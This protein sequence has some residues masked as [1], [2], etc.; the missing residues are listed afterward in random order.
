MITMP[1]L[2]NTARPSK[3]RPL[4]HAIASPRAKDTIV[5]LAYSQNQMQLPFIRSERKLSMS[6]SLIWV[7]ERLAGLMPCKQLDLDTRSDNGN[8]RCEAKRSRRSEIWMVCLLLQTQRKGTRMI[9]CISI[10]KLSNNSMIMQ[11]SF[12]AL[13]ICIFPFIFVQKKNIP[14]ILSVTTEY[15]FK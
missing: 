1:S 15:L 14:M 9:T 12:K 6:F 4:A 11:L 8:L 2:P 3:I 13:S 5:T 10:E 7:N